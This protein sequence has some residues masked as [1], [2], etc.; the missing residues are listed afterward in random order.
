[1]KT[2][3]DVKKIRYGTLPT[4]IGQHATTRTRA[5]VPEI[6]R[7]FKRGHDVEGRGSDENVGTE[8]DEE[9]Q[10]YLFEAGET[11]VFRGTDGLK[12]NLLRITINVSKDVTP[13]TKV[14]GNFLLEPEIQ[15]NGSVLFYE[16]PVKHGILRDEDENIVTIN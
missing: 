16:D 12:F 5:A 2:L 9:L 8:N 3:R 10:E 15:H 6:S 1:M 11:V 13:R 4:V 14:R 7:L